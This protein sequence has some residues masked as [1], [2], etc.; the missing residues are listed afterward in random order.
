MIR[1][2]NDNRTDYYDDAGEWHRED[3]LPAVILKNGDKFY[4]EHG[5]RH[6]TDGPAIDCAKP[7]GIHP[8]QQYFYQGRYIECQTTEEF[9]RSIKMLAF[10]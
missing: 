1:F 3:N 5:K 2:S 4:F 8:A 9:I 6:R 7:N 10:I